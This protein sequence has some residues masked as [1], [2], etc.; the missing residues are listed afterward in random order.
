MYSP[1]K[2]IFLLGQ[3]LAVSIVVAS[4]VVVCSMA[5]AFLFGESC[6]VSKFGFLNYV[7]GNY[8]SPQNCKVEFE[9]KDYC[10][11]GNTVSFVVKVGLSLPML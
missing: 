9:W 3:I 2:L 7:T 5:P 8:L 6:A 4:G 1:S 10:V 11:V